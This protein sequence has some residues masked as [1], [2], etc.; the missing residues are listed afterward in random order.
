MAPPLPPKPTIGPLVRRTLFAAALGGVAGCGSPRQAPRIGPPPPPR[1]G[2]VVDPT[3]YED[4]ATPPDA[5]PAPEPDAAEPA[6]VDAAPVIDAQTAPVE[7]KPPRIGPPP[8]KALPTPPDRDNEI[9]IGPPT[10]DEEKP[11][12]IG[13]A[14][15]PKSSMIRGEIAGPD[16]RPLTRASLRVELGGAARIVATDGDGRFVLDGVLP[17]EHAVVI[18]AGGFAPARITLAPDR[19]NRV[20]LTVAPR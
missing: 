15:G 18:E 1:I 7:K 13:L 9:R 5:A 3:Q 2:A 19:D 14:P 6:P 17:G 10:R 8:K 16:G 12:R 4:P 11:I 20:R